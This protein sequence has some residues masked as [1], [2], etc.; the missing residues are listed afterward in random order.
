MVVMCGGGGG[1]SSSSGGSVVVG[2]VVFL[3]VSG[4]GVSVRLARAAGKEKMCSFLYFL[5]R[6]YFFFWIWFF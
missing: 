3:V 6:F 2:V 1:G 5:E 4:R